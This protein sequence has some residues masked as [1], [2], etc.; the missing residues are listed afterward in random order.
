LT[1]LQGSSK[2]SVELT[3]IRIGYGSE[4]SDRSIR[5]KQLQELITTTVG[6]AE[7]HRLARA[8]RGMNHDA[9]LGGM[10][11]GQMIADILAVEF[12]NLPTTKSVVRF[13]QRDQRSVR[14]NE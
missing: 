7:L 11:Y 13:R 14:G 4:M 2:Y 9:S 8:A 5:E 3:Q 10:L 12:P 6:R 1:Q